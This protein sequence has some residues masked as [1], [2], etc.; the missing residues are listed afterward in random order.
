[1]NRIPFAAA[2]AL[3][4]ACCPAPR[5]DT[6][7]VAQ[8]E[9]APPMPP[10]PAP[11]RPIDPPAPVPAPVALD[12]DAAG[13][14][15]TKPPAPLP[16]PAFVP[17]APTRFTLSNGAEVLLV[18]N[19]RLPLVSVR[20]AIR[21]AGS[22]SDGDLPGLAAFAADLL[23]EG[24][25]PRSAIELPEELERLGADLSVHASADHGQITL[26]TMAETLEPALAIAA[27]VLLRPRLDPADFERVKQERLA[28]LALRGDQPRQI[29]AL[30]F[31]RV[32]YGAHP[33]APPGAGYTASVE[34]IT[35]PIVKAFWQKN[36]GPG[37]TTIVLAG[38]VTAADARRILEAQLG[39]W[40]TR[41]KAPRAP[42]PARPAKPGIA[43]VD[44]PGA[45]QSVVV[46]GRL[47]PDARDPRRAANDVVN[48]AIGGSF[49]ARLNASLREQKGYTYGIFSSF[50]RGQWG[51]AWSATS[52]I[53]TDVTGPAIREALDIIAAAGT[54][55]LPAEEL[56]KA[57]SLLVRGLPQD[58]ET[59]ASVAGAFAALSVDGRPL[60][61]YRD[62][63]AALNRVTAA[64]AQAQAASAWRDLSIVIVGDWAAVGDAVTAL[65]LPIARYDIE[66]NPLPAGK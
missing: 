25:G 48:T 40:K 26:D 38:A 46:I 14:D 66:G 49:A 39:G 11:D 58:F 17:P 62:L 10:D 61:Y 63:P 22:R 1:M 42:K 36:Y 52:S 37:A 64:D 41:V 57:K 32:L 3:V 47:G 60:T 44:R 6:T 18:E 2:F 45:P 28:D 50:W 30:V 65:G 54:A 20:F 21:S 33:Y 27:D 4:A 15:W 5:Q 9:P 8:P 19:H 56:A 51:G 59:N 29:A 31:E 35:L 12:W 13:I 43:F 24:A 55:P 53:R 7:P 16:E 34:K 23:D